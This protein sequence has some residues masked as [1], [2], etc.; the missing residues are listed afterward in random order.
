MGSV[1]SFDNF[2]AT[3]KKVMVKLVK[4]KE[5][6]IQLQTLLHEPVQDHGPVSPQQL[7]LQIYRSFS[8]SLSELSSCTG[9]TGS[10]QIPAVDCG[11]SACSGESKKKRGVKDQRGCY[12]RRRT[13]D[14]RVT[15]SPTMEDGCAWRKYGQKIILNSEY[16]RCYFRC[17]HKS[18]GCKALKQVQRVKGD[19]ILYQ[20][21]Y[22]N[23]HTCK[24]TLRAPPTLL[25][26]SDPDPN[27]ISFETSNIPSKQA[28]K[29]DD[30]SNNY[31]S[32]K[33]PLIK[34]EDSQLSDEDAS[35]EAKST[36]EDPWHDI[37]TGLDPLGYKPA[38][39]PYQEE[40]ESAS[41]HGLDME[42]DQLSDIENF[43]Y[44]F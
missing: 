1:S 5:I 21:T 19:E 33:P 20:T 18:D 42:V 38:W 14:S 31:N 16:P 34:Q 17:T 29:D 13:S 4:G 25:M 24:E 9:P 3:K 12:K 37:T 6:A 22:F 11:G 8:D 41:L 30:Q 39:A 43:N 10:A 7:A 36:L 2:H 26:D 28:D 27:L 32:S 40:V 35:H 44:I 23:H 15:V